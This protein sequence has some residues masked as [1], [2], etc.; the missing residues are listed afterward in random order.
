VSVSYTSRPI[1]RSI[2]CSMACVR[3]V[4]GLLLSPDFGAVFAA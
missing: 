2:V 4:D 1:F 3:M